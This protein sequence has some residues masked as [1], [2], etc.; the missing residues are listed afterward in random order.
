MRRR[1]GRGVSTASPC[2]ALS[3]WAGASAC[4]YNPAAEAPTTTDRKAEGKQVCEM[5]RQ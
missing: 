5:V 1:R 2:A 4:G 3:V